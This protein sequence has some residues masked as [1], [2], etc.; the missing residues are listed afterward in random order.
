MVVKK[1]RAPLSMTKAQLCDEVVHL[2]KQLDTMIRTVEWYADTR[3][4]RDGHHGH[5]EQGLHSH[6]WRLDRGKRARQA[7][8]ME[9]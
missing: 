6:W 7:L 1:R 9:K 4:L 5:E 3:N 8:G 2:R